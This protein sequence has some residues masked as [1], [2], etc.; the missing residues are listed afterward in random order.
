LESY[1]ALPLLVAGVF[2]PGTWHVDYTR[3][4]AFEIV[5]PG[6]PVLLTA[7]SVAMLL[8]AAVLA[9]LWLRAARRRDVSPAAV[10][11]LAT[12]TVA[13]VVVTDKTLSP[14]Y[15]LWIGA[16]LAAMGVGG[17]AE[18]G[19]ADEALP[20]A[21]RLMLATALLTQLFYPTMYGL[22]IDINPV[23]VAVIVARDV[24]LGML[25]WLALSR[26]WALTSA[27]RSG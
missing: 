13:L 5:G 4:L 6:V 25:T 2:S 17:G 22:L 11:W 18:S 23:A 1:A 14:Q 8:A 27:G 10:G 21:T 3:F 24:V 19:T 20:R 26:F 12:A 9:V 16:L 7:A 15:L